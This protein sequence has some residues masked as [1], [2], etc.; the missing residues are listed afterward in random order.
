MLSAAH[1]D[2]HVVKLNGREVHSA[3]GKAPALVP[4]HVAAGAR[5]F[6]LAPRELAFVVLLGKAAPACSGSDIRRP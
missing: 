4:R 3:G 2:S 5:E 1:L 6:Q